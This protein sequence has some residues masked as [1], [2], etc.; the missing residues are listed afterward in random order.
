[1]MNKHQRDVV[2]QLALACAIQAAIGSAR[3]EGAERIALELEE[4]LAALQPAFLL[5]A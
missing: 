2:Q 3:E 4:I 5:A 1:M